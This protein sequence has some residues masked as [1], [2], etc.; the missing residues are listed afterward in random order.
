MLE[1]RRIIRS[2]LCK[3]LVAENSSF[4]VEIAVS[5]VIFQIVTLA[6]CKQVASRLSIS[7]RILK[8]QS[9]NLLRCAV[10]WQDI[11]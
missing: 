3:P 7:A 9:G 10:D 5:H 11:G 6:L 2:S 8:G 4:R 1:A